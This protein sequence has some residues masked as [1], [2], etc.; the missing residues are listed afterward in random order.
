M[1]SMAVRH[2][3]RAPPPLP[4]AWMPARARIAPAFGLVGDTSRRVDGGGAAS[5]GAETA[6]AQPIRTR[7]Q[8]GGRI[9]NQRGGDSSAEDRRP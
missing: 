4:L 5:D 9:N 2:G 6:S 7:L 8:R 3:A 1:A